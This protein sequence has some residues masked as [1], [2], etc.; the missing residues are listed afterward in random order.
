MYGDTVT[1]WTYED[2][3][4]LMSKAADF[5]SDL[6]LREDGGMEIQLWADTGLGD[7]PINR[8]LR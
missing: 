2:E 3:H 8:S 1:E 4:D 7:C 6:L 5:L